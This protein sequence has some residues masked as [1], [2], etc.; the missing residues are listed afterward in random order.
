MSISLADLGITPAAPSGSETAPV[1]VEAEEPKTRRMRPGSIA[2]KV[3]YSV[4]R[5]QPVTVVKA[6]PGAGKTTLLLEVIDHLASRTELKI[7]VVCPTRNGVTDVSQRLIAL[8]ES[9]PDLD[10]SV[11]SQDKEVTHTEGREASR[12][13]TVG[14]STVAS[15]V[16]DP[17]K[18]DVLVVDEAYQTTV[19][20]VLM[21]ADRSAQIVMVGDSGQIGPVVTHNTSPWDGMESGPHLR[22]PD[23]FARREDAVVYNMEGTYRLG[24]DTVRVIEPLYDFGFDSLRPARHLATP[25]GITLPEISSHL[26]DKAALADAEAKGAESKDVA[27]FLVTWVERLLTATLTETDPETGTVTTRQMEPADVAVVVSRNAQASAVEAMLGAHALSEV[28]VGTADRLQGGQW[29]AVV[30]L[31]PLVGSQRISD[32]QVNLGRLCVM[33]SR[34]M[35]HLVWVHDGRS[36]DRLTTLVEETWDEHIRTGIEVRRRL[37]GAERG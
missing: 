22:A 25:K 13:Q 14:V 36:I 3:L 11:I 23:V 17:R 34:H 32:H 10:Y 19:A 21:A 37:T 26:L 1:P 6:P 7:H 27:A 20:D 33:L 31:D 29:P 35:A 2:A 12:D 4:Y 8:A 9:F 30:A 18:C 24:E 16:L 5:G 28:T 15:C